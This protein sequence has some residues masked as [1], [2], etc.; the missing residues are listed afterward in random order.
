MSVKLVR[1][2]LHAL[3]EELNRPGPAR[4]PNALEEILAR[5]D[6]IAERMRAAG[7]L[8]EPTPEDMEHI[9]A[10]FRDRFGNVPLGLAK[11]Q[12]ANP[13]RLSPT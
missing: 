5:L 13:A 11:L 6:H 4:E 7:E 10:Y 8:P 2:E 9:A 3:R 1:Q 12:K